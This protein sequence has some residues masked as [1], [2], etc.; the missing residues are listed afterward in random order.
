MAA[1]ASFQAEGSF[2]LKLAAAMYCFA[3]LGMFVSTTGV[4]LS[5]VKAD[6][7][8]LS[9]TQVSLL[10]LAAPVGYL[11][12]AQLNRR[13]HVRYGRRGI[14][15]VGPLLHIG[16]AGVVA[17]H[18]P[19]P[20]VLGAWVIGSLGHGVV[21]GS[22]CAWA[23]DLES[24]SAASGMLHGAYSAGA[25]LGPFLAGT[26]ISREGQGRWYEW[27]YILVGLIARFF[28]GC[29]YRI[30]VHLI[31]LLRRLPLPSWNCSS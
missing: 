29:Y 9:D 13:I 23:G 15:V 4:I 14:A 20:I 31:D 22:V 7:G 8:G 27:F 16:M 12:A 21:D 26:L 24:A 10:F 5:S 19:F 25:G 30:E 17:L 18:P 1:H 11:V 28:S 2:A 3:V 6:Y